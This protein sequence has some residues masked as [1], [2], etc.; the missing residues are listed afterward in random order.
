MSTH[1]RWTQVAIG[2]TAIALGLLALSSYQ[3]IR[4]LA[5]AKLQDNALL[6]VSRGR[7]ELDRWLAL[8][9]ASVL[10][11]AHAPPV[12]S[13]DWAQAEPYLDAEVARLQPD[14][15]HAILANPD[16]T[17]YFTGQGFVQGKNIADRDYFQTAIAG[18]VAI[19]Q[20]HIS[21]AIGIAKITILLLCPSASRDR[22]SA[23]WPA[24]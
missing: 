7:D 1:P 17:Y 21:R 16:G 22:P 8:Q 13:M 11:L 3:Q 24:A 18:S 10:A 15:D 2:G 20:P 4:S 14:L 9:K 19:S 23:S 6:E 5:L 12:V